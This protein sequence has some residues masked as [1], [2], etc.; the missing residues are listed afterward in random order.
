ML[1]MVMLATVEETP[2]YTDGAVA[3]LFGQKEFNGILLA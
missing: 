3:L 2:D 1:V